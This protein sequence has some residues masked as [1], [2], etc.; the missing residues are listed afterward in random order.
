MCAETTDGAGFQSRRSLRIR[1]R[2]DDRGAR[3]N[4]PLRIFDGSLN[5]TARF[6]GAR[7]NGETQSNCNQAGNATHGNTP[8]VARRH[9]REAALPKSNIELVVI[10]NKIEVKPSGSGNYPKF[11]EANRSPALDFGTYCRVKKR[12]QI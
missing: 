9:A 3:D 5:S 2:H 7:D 1:V 10:Q 6:L 4:A 11:C 12:Q 8:S